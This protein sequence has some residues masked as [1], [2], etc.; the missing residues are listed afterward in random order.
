MD[1]IKLNRGGRE[2]TFKKDMTSFAVRLR[3][4]K[5]INEMVLAQTCGCPKTEVK[6]VESV[7]TE[8]M[9]IFSVKESAKLEQ[10]MNE[11]RKS[12]A[13]DVISHMYF[14]D[15]VP[16]GG[17][18]PNGTMTLQFKPE[19]NTEER[20]KILEECGLEVLEDIDFLPYGYTVRLT[21][22]SKE[23]PLKTAY[24]LQQRKKEIKAAE[25][26]LTFRIS[27]KYTPNDSLFYL[28]WYLENKGNMQGLQEGADVKAEEAWDY[29]RGDREIVVCVMDDGFDLEHPDFNVP[30]KIVAPRDF[31]QDDFDP[32]PDMED[33]NHG[34]ACA[35]VAIAEENGIGVV[36][37][38]PQCSFMPIRT[39]GW[40]SDN[41]I[42]DLFQYAIDNH[43]DVISC[44]W[45]AADWNFPLSTLM[46]GI[47]HKAATEGRQNGKGCVILFAAGNEDR[48]LD[49]TKDGQISHQ[50]FA[51]HPDVISVG[52]SN[53]LDKRSW[54]SNYGP[55]LSIC[56]PSS[57]SPGRAIV[58]TDRRGTQGY[59]SGDYTNGFG[60]TSSAT[61]L[62]A[63]L[64]AL[65]L[66]VN[67]DLTSAEVKTFIMDTADQ[68]DQENGQYVDGHSPQYGRGRI[69]A[70]KAVAL[71]AGDSQEEQLPEVLFMEHRV[72]K[73]IPDLGE[74]KDPV[75]FPLDVTIQN[76][77][78]NVEIRHTY[79]SDLRVILKS[80]Q[81]N[82]IILQDRTGGSQDDIIKSFRS[83]NE[84]DL[85][86]PVIG[87]PAKGD[88]HLK[89]MDV[90]E[91]DEGTLV[92]WGLAISY[93]GSV[94]NPAKR[95]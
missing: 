29:T 81:G 66:S 83:S 87:K 16:G 46:H 70:H 71:V 33:D 60:G 79:S 57:G 53:S 15:D 9:D 36:G 92:K 94:I 54:Y 12:P 6:H 85:F 63:G 7:A 42:R 64:A 10:T 65:I 4:G 17:V 11:L 80:P 20:G 13:S 77:E 18:I 40:I 55:E 34:T 95:L 72:N 52:A 73:K 22:A 61:P 27:Y 5:A 78:V 76:I 26:N 82:E 75:I 48:P 21:G 14:L 39:S 47:I 44:S 49:G 68:I 62:A 43:A 24:K 25:P 88:W 30:G 41:S 59:S 1:K 90:A 45:S 28:Q 56:A 19:V 2:V 93:S 51:L 8:K 50:G 69:N 32:N 37:L 38:A 89:V 84:P 23:N 58:T 35:G 91:Q 86:A 74:Y 67:S 3:Q 31:G